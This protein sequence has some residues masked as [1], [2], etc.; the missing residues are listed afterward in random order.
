MNCA[1][2]SKPPARVPFGKRAYCPL[3]RLV[4]ISTKDGVDTYQ[5]PRCKSVFNFETVFGC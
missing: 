5:C 3:I 1:K 4:K 2:C